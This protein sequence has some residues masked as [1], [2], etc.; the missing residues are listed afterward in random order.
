[1]QINQ[2]FPTPVAFFNLE[3]PLSEIERDF[4]LN[5]PQRTN[6]GNTSSENNYLCEQPEMAEIKQFFLN[7]V[8][9]YFQEIHQPGPDASLR[10]TQ[11]WANYTKPSQFHH[12]HAHPNSYISGVFYVQ[13]NPG[14]DKIYFY[15][16]GYQQIKFNVK[17]WNMY[18]SESWWFD[19]V[20]TQL[21]LFPSHLEHMVQT[22]AE[23]SQTRISIS[24]N[25]FPV[26]QL[27]DNNEL[28]QLLL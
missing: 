1:M 3:R 19:S 18:N 12:K 17:N 23:N 2:L 16:S 26:G 14:S 5:Q 9:H 6:M 15:R 13:T 8:N 27:G 28:T 24:F 22:L 21:I 25:T 4:I 20:E 7:S 10:I 11:S